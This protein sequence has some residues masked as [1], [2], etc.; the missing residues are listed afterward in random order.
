MP[1]AKIVKQLISTDSNAKRKKLLAEIAVTEHL[2]LAYKLKE[3]CYVAWTTEPAKVKN[4]E[5]V[6]QNLLELNPLDE[7]KALLFWVSGIAEITAGKFDSAVKNLDKSAEIFRRIN[8]EHESAKTQT[9]KLY[10]LALLGRYDKAVLCGNEALRIFEKYNDEFEAGKVELNVGNLYWR[11]DFYAES[12]PY[13]ISAH[14]RFSKINDVRHLAMVENCQAF[15]KALQNNFREAETIYKQAL[16]RCKDDNLTVTEAEIEIGMSN[17]YLFQGKFDS[18]LQFLERA[19]KKYDSL[20]MPHQSANC[21]LEI[22]DI[23]LELNLLPEARGFYELSAT[24]FTEFGMQSELG[25]CFLNLAK[26]LFL[27]GENTESANYSMK[28]REVFIAEGNKLSAASVKFAEAHI[29]Y[30]ENKLEIAESTVKEAL[31]T[32]KKSKS[33]RLELLAKRFLGEIYKLQGKPQ[34]A[35]KLL[36]ETLKSAKNNLPQIEYLCL[37]SLGEI[38]KNEKFLIEAVKLIENSRTMLSAEELRT[39]FVSDKL[40]PYNELIKLC[41]RRQ[42]FPEALVWSERSR[43]RTLLETMQTGTSNQSDD[44]QLTRLREELNWFYGR[45]YRES[46]SGLDVRKEK[47]KLRETINLREKEYA[48][49]LRR[50]QISENTEFDEITGFSLANLQEN[51][52]E[53]TL[54]EYIS[55]DEKISA[56]V[57][58]QNKIE[59]FQDIA[60]E[61]E[62]NRE[63]EQFIF[64]IKTARFR[65]KLSPEN[66]KTAFT[67]MLGHSNK[68]YDLLIR[69]FSQSIKTDNLTII[70]TKFLHYLPFQALHNGDNYL[71]ETAEIS[72]SPSASI[73]LSCLKRYFNVPDS[74]L[75]IGVSDEQT[76][77]I[78]TEIEILGKLFKKSIKLV[79]EDATLENLHKNLPD[80]NV[81][82]LAC[83]GKFRHDNP[84]FSSLRLFN[85]NLSVNDTRNLDLKNKLV[86]L[87]ACETGLNKIVAGEELIG[88]AR[89]FL[90][91]GASS[92]VLSLWAVNDTATLDL[93][94]EFYRNLPKS[95]NPKKSLQAA[96]IKLLKKNPHPYFWS[97]FILVG[98]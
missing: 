39:S 96:Q 16:K 65:H 21:V 61:R 5:L 73:W 31:R 86:V 47:T 18:A 56:F 11:R 3:T 81:L 64:Q 62:V 38:T 76:P 44:K 93:M 94:R 77:L 79:N 27:S 12:E 98:K 37:V 82:H 91:A 13:L 87:S 43:S 67:R 53:T 29:F 78:K 9:A 71:I 59:F 35:E 57:I 34:K 97:P 8:R 66:Q 41:L 20:G 84:S 88:L 32:F 95:S 40:L 68:L 42:D 80:T 75:L 24:K 14:H 72:Y 30:R 52:G 92:L 4:A 74:A 48:E 26:T 63:T 51:L 36:L 6:L 46:G 28:A 49:K 58:S 33:I 55:A 85:E 15:V 89:G 54:I 2:K 83:H 69:P 19:R 90:S 7:I 60:D 22:A 10:A 17:L 45:L 25:K 70:P 23:Y 50:R 1:Y